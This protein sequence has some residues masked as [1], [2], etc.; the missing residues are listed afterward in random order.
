MGTK[1]T[2]LTELTATAAT[3]DFLHII[4]VSDTSGGSAGTSKKIQITNLPSG[5]GGTTSVITCRNDTGSTIAKGKAVYISGVVS[6]TPT[7][8]LADNSSSSTMAAVGVTQ[9]SIANSA[10]GSVVIFGELDTIDTSSFTAGDTLYVGTSG[11]LT[12]TKPTGTA[13]IQNIAACIKV[14]ASTGS[15]VIEGAGRTNDVPNIPDGQAWIGN[16][17]G[18]ATPT[19]LADVATGGAITDLTDTPASLG[20]ANQVMQVNSGGTAL[21][22]VSPVR[23]LDGLS[24]VTLGSL[25]NRQTLVY[26]SATSEF[27]NGSLNLADAADVSSASPTN[28]QVLSYNSTSGDWEPR[29]ISGGGGGTNNMMK[30]FAFFDNNVRDV[31]IPMSSESEGTSIQRYNRFV[32]PVDMDVTKIV[33]YTGY[34]LSGGTGGSIQTG[35]V[36]GSSFTAIETQSFSSTTSGGVITLTFTATSFTAGNIYVFKMNNGF[37]SA[38]GNIV[39]SILF[40]V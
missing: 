15:I 29:T 33:F 23:D 16:A 11:D 5:G 26:S 14:S 1:V 19:T 36:T 21:E 8:A 17:S 3:G 7:I 24:D 28:E 30:T 6:S 39:G 40:E 38:Y 22:F 20:T 31:Y 35:S 32:C 37:G 12:S 4:D 13:L 9:D 27:R 25:V 18:V 34:G 10:D 2:D